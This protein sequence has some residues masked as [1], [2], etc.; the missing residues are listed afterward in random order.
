MEQISPTRSA[1][2]V[3]ATSLAAMGVG[4][5]L[6]S[7]G[8]DFIDAQQPIDWAHWLILIG[9]AGGALA[10]S[11]SAVGRLGR[12]ARALVMVGAIAFGGMVAI[13]LM[14]WTLPA[15]P[16]LDDALS[17]ALDAPQIAVPFL[18]VG[19]SLF[20]IGLALIALEWVG[21]NAWAAGAVIVGTV[22]NGIGQAT[23]VDGIVLVSFV[24]MLAGLVGLLVRAKPQLSRRAAV[25][26][27]RV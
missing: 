6:F 22:L 1:V 21:S 24:I 10:T 23:G 19:P 13:D 15:D 3:L 26:T 14:L 27:V 5:L 9:A 7:F 8:R 18:W 4:Q 16:M 20:F 17:A 25:P 11:G 12:V 2:L